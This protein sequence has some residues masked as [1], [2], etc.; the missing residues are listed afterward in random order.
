M[1]WTNV[2]LF[3]LPISTYILGYLMGSHTRFNTLKKAFMQGANEGVRMCMLKIEDILMKSK[4]L[5]MEE[6]NHE[7]D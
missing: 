4:T 7:Q 3:T 1:E 6:D 2:L 5:K